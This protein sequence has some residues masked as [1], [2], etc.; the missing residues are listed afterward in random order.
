MQTKLSQQAVGRENEKKK[1]YVECRSK[2]I[3]G[4]H[5]RSGPLQTIAAYPRFNLGML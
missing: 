2:P 1:Y 3:P 5:G 4:G